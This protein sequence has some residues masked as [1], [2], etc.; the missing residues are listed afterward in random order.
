MLLLG[1]IA[2]FAIAAPALAESPFDGTW[3]IDLGSAKLP[4]KPDAFLLKDGMYE[5]QSCVP[6]VKVKAD[7]AFHPVSGHPY[8]DAVS[9]KVVDP[10]T[11]VETDRKGAKTVVSATSTV[12]ANGQT[13][14]FSFKDTTAANGSAVTGKGTQTRVTKG[15]AGSHAISGSWRTTSLTNFSENGLTLTFK[16]EGD[17][18]SMSTPTGQ[19]YTAKFGGPAVPI[20]GDTGGTHAT[21]K[22]LGA[23]S[24][25][26]TDT[27]GGKVV[28]VVTATVSPDGK[29][30]TAAVEDRERGSHATYKLAKQ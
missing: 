24:F 10:H 30:M 21:V 17:A 12:S 1:L 5:C 27:R 29:T 6:V 15:P 16:E 23:R 20:K 26:E 13:L 2:P 28:S 19:S 7:G 25:Q 18:L 9:I 3:K 22:K 8:Y 4:E 11:I 14:N